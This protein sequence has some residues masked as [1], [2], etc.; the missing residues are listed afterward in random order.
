M[1]RYVQDHAYMDEYVYCN[2]Q[3]PRVKQG[4][5]THTYWWHTRA[6]TQTH[7]HTH[8]KQ[9]E[10][11]TQ[12]RKV[13]CVCVCVCV[14]QAWG[15]VQEMYGFTIAAWL[16]GIKKFDLYLNM[17][18]QPPWDTRLNMTDKKP[19]YILHYTYGMDYKLTGGLVWH[20]HMRV[21]CVCVCSWHTHRVATEGTASLRVR[22]IVL[23]VAHSKAV[24]N[25]HAHERTHTKT[26]AKAI[27]APGP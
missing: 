15:W 9:R 7:T 18:S 27:R 5:N 22:G 6:R 8:A 24:V 25:T 19:Y 13:C 26:V 23:C 17:M 20:E 4:N 1:G 11:W 2:F 16:A 3:R 10:S 21:V 14:S 12:R